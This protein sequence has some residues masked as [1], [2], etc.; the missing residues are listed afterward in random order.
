MSPVLL[1]NTSLEGAPG[2]T[3][4]RFMSWAAILLA[5]YLLHRYLTRHSLSAEYRRA[6]ARHP[7]IMGAVTAGI[8]VHWW[9]RDPVEPR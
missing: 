5:D 3:Y 4:S 1:S 7:W 2:S 8:L 9:R 6:R